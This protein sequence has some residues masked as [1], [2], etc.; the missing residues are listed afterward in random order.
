M[1]FKDINIKPSYES[2]VDDIIEEFYEP[3]LSTSIQYDRIAGFFSS[4]S[5]AIA[6]R[7]MSE[8]IKNG[9]RMRLIT[10]P[11]LNPDDA[12]VI[13]KFITSYESLNLSDFGI[14]LDN[15]Q[16]DFEKNHVKAL[17]WLLKEDRLEIKMAIPIDDKS[18]PDFK[19]MNKGIFHQKVGL[20]VD[21]KGNELSFSG[22][23]NESAS[24]WVFNDEEFKVFMADMYPVF[25]QS[26]KN[27]FNDIWNGKRNNLKIY[28][29]PN[30]VKDN[31]IKYSN[32]FDIESISIKRYREKRNHNNFSLTPISL[33]SYQEKA[34]KKWIQSDYR[35]L[36]EMA[37]GT[38]KTRTALASMAYL[39]NRIESL[40]VVI[41]TPQNVLSLQWID[42]INDLK[43]SYDLLSI[44][45]GT[46][47][48][49]RT[50]LENMLL[51]NYNGNKHAKHCIILTT[52]ATS[53][54]V[55]FIDLISNNTSTR[56]RTLFIGDEVHWLGARQ[57]RRA[58]LNKYDYRIGLSATPTR[59][60]DEDGSAF[61]MNYFGDSKFEFTIKDAL[62]TRNPRTGLPFLVDY[63]YYIQQ[64]HLNQEETERY[65]NVTAR[66]L[67][68][69][70][71][72]DK[73]D[74]QSDRLQRLLEERANIIKNAEEKITALSNL[75]DKLN[76]DDS[77]HDLIIFV[78]PQQID[79]VI[80]ILFQKG[81]YFHRLT[82]K[83]GT[84]KSA[85]YNGLSEREHIIKAFKKGLFQ[86]IIAIKCLDEG[87]DIPTASRGII[88]SSSTNPREYV[89]R[90]GRIIRQ[91]EG[92]DN[93]VLFDFCVASVTGLNKDEIE[94][95]KRI[96]N[97]ELVR[98]KEIA[99]NAINHAEVLK[100]LSTF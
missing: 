75:I 59:W 11:K 89:Q 86:V 51:E 28:D 84:K 79:T 19:E 96:K 27:R 12:N 73:N 21:E 48:N 22:S 20:L 67:N 17:G 100:T 3:A 62:T 14:D 8:F 87:I 45:D 71:V 49:W 74:E 55:D 6:A 13:N 47:Q 43:I 70:R 4:S 66:I 25:F 60:F 2:G 94:L 78:S 30:A 65:K 23:I 29:L 15:I 44:I 64:I 92:K 24:A 40:I 57:Y 93:A 32:N 97:K 5:L 56:T 81:I 58:L 34:V 26:D 33:F 35:L 83:E 68:L 36:F 16:S 38:G 72:K 41:S 98:I 88:L 77:I 7:G 46:C 53:S 39:F 95:E 82:E 31:I 52:H 80:K 85:K 69:Y 90:I 18:D 37:T 91:S 99:T 54:S 61:I 42:S 50:D 9:G 10:S 63:Y 1:S 76:Q